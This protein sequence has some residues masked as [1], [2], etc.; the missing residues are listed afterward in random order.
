MKAYNN[1]NN[2]NHIVSK[3]EKFITW[4]LVLFM[5]LSTYATPISGVTIGDFMLLLVLIIIIF[6]IIKNKKDIIEVISIPVLIYLIYIFIVTL[7]F[8][9]NEP[10][11]LQDTILSLSRYLLFLITVLF[12][13][14]KYFN[15]KYGYKVYV[16]MALLFSG[17]IIIQFI[18]FYQFEIILPETFFGLPSY[19]LKVSTEEYF[20]KKYLLYRP[21]SVF[22]EPSHFAVFNIIALYIVLNSHIVK[23]SN[24]YKKGIFLTIGIVISGSSTGIILLPICWFKQLIKLLKRMDM[25][26]LVAFISLLLVMIRMIYTGYFQQTIARVWTSEG[27]RGNAVQGRFGKF[28]IL[29]EENIPIMKKIFGQG[30]GINVGYYLPSFGTLYL[31]LGIMGLIVFFLVIAY[32]YFNSIQE[33][34]EIILLIL[35]IFFG[36]N[37]LFG[38]SIVLFFPIIFS[39]FQKQKQQL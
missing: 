14:K 22:L 33:I 3:S 7:I 1:I 37:G 23:F 25:K 31:Y 6:S 4:I 9:V 13:S 36:T 17:Y 29:F 34:K 12:A 21:R 32:Q 10:Y 8:W 24:K 20:R 35:I 15:I 5:P 19:A 38:I 2:K 39:D 28:K 26:T 18:S 30:F 11:K 16:T 27:F